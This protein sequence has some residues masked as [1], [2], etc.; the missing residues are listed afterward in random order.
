MHGTRQR[1][2][3]ALAVVDVDRESG[4]AQQIG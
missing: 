3:F 1:M 2:D 4:Q